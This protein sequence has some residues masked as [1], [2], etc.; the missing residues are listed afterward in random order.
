VKDEF[1]NILKL[2]SV[3]FTINGVDSALV[4][5]K[6]KVNVGKGYFVTEIVRSTPPEFNEL[7]NTDSLFFTSVFSLPIAVV[8]PTNLD[9]TQANPTLF[10]SWIGGSLILGNNGLN[11]NGIVTNADSTHVIVTTGAGKLKLTNANAS[12]VF[13]VATTLGKPGFITINNLGTTDNFAVNVADSVKANGTTGPTI[14]TEFVNKTWDIVEQIPGGSNATLTIT[15]SAADE[16]PGFN[17]ANCG[18]AHFENGLWKGFGAGPATVNANGTFTKTVTGF[19]NFSPFSITSKASVLPIKWLSV[20]AMLDN[21]NDVLVTWK[22]EELLIKN[23][24]VEKS[25]D[26]INFLPI[27][28]KNSIGNGANNYFVVDKLSS[29]DRAVYYRIKQTSLDGNE[30]YSSIVKVVNNKTLFFTI[31]PNPTIQKSILRINDR[32]IIGQTYTIVNADG[33]TIYNGTINDWENEIDLGN[34][35][36]GI[37]LIKISGQYSGFLIKQ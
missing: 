25:L 3:L 4:F 9:L 27:A 12:N 19:N 1:H 16:L 10:P 34:N 14:L 30:S 33:K 32:S 36:A 11:V 26:A 37:Y 13:P 20:N 5:K 17:R 15:W 31:Y 18:I 22:V 24:E 23:Y 8:V 28:V 35:A 2:D 6:M 21:N 7:N 29:N